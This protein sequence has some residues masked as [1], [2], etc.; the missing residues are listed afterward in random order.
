ML[1]AALGR[2]NNLPYLNKVIVIWNGPTPPNPSTVWPK[3]SAPIVVNER[4]SD[5]Q[6]LVKESSEFDF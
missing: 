3:L 4:L 2:L 6:A 1:I 5:L